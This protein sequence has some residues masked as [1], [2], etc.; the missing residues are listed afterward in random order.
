MIYWLFVPSR[1]I[2]SINGILY[3]YIY[4]M[5]FRIPRV[6]VSLKKKPVAGLGPFS[7]RAKD[8]D[9]EEERPRYKGGRV[10]WNQPP[11]RRLF[12]FF[13]VLVICFFF[14]YIF[15]YSILY[16][17]SFSPSR[18]LEFISSPLWCYV[19]PYI[20]LTSTLDRILPSTSYNSGY[21]NNKRFTFFSSTVFIFF[22][23]GGGYSYLDEMSCC[24][25]LGKLLFIFVSRK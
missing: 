19:F 8:K 15:L 17:T 13:L 3:I 16:F 22:V 11:P 4:S 5:C 10:R 12:F 2:Q 1:V 23:G 18:Q 25:N 21:S 24:S 7:D 20:V 6:C 9:A 14:P